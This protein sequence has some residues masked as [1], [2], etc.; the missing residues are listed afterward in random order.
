M[1]NLE[2]SEKVIIGILIAALVLGC[3]VILY[4]KYA[5]IGDLRI[6]SS[7][8]NKHTP[9]DITKK[10]RMININEASVETLMGLKGIGKVLAGRIVEYRTK[11]GSFITVDD[12]KKVPG[13]GASLF[14]KI[15]DS[16]ILE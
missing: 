8:V 1:I 5:P 2:R 9:R 12:L 6:E 10:V 14:E 3:G 15:K 13:I 16:I 7:T 4:R 11:N